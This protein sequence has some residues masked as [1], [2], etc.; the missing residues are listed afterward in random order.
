MRC[1]HVNWA[2][3]N[4]MKLSNFKDIIVNNSEVVLDHILEDGLLKY[5]PIINNLVDL[6]N[7]KTTISDKIFYRKVVSF[8]E[9]FSSVDRD[10]F[11]KWNSWAR[12][13]SESSEKIASTLV[14][15]ID[16][17]HDLIKC[18]IIGHIFKKL[19]EEKISLNDFEA[20]VYATSMCSVRDLRKHCIDGGDLS[21][22]TEASLAQRLQFVG[23]YCFTPELLSKSAKLEYE[24]TDKGCDFID[25]MKEFSW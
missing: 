14:L 24:I 13:N 23:F 11:D 8:Y 25:S 21:S 20:Y 15:H 2:L 3:G 7:V 18:K 19:V 12:E 1:S 5:I 4:L 17:Q 16:S 6:Y 9:S 10:S 22:S